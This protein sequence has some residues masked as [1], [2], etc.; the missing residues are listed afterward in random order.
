MIMDLEETEAWN[1]CAGKCQQQYIQP[2]KLRDRELQDGS[3]LATV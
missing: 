1:D 2:T 3:E